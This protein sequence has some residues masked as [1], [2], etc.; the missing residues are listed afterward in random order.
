MV[1]RITYKINEYRIHVHT[2]SKR[3]IIGHGNTADAD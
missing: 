3:I 1:T 2:F